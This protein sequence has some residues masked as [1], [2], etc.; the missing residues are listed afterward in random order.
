MKA[1]II[2]V[3]VKHIPFRLTCT[4]FAVTWWLDLV[5]VAY[6]WRRVFAPRS[7]TLESSSKFAYKAHKKRKKHFISHHDK[8]EES[9]CK[10]WLWFVK[11]SVCKKWITVAKCLTKH[12]VKYFGVVK[13]ASSPAPL[14]LGNFWSEPERWTASVATGVDW[15]HLHAFVSGT[16]IW[17]GLHVLTESEKEKCVLLKST[18]FRRHFQGMYI[19]ESSGCSLSFLNFWLSPVWEELVL[20]GCRPAFSTF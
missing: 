10:D 11:G 18:H 20:R 5:A 14:I 4:Q 1:C 17:E 12:P 16:L 6:I 9:L 8:G 15:Q 7:C 3:A 19:A 2:F 13:Q